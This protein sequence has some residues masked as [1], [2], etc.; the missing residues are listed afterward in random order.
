MGSANAHVKFARSD[1][2]GKQRIG[3][4]FWE[5]LAS[6]ARGDSTVVS[7]RLFSLLKK[8][9]DEPSTDRLQNFVDRTAAKQT[10]RVA[11][12]ENGGLLRIKDD[13]AQR[14]VDVRNR[15][16][17]LMQGHFADLRRVARESNNQYAIIL[18]Q[19]RAVET[20][21]GDWGFV[22]AVAEGKPLCSWTLDEKPIRPLHFK[23][24]RAEGFSESQA[25]E[26]LTKGIE[27][28]REQIASG[29]SSDP[30]LGPQALEDR[31]LA[32]VREQPASRREVRRS[33]SS[34]RRL[35]PDRVGDDFT[36][37]TKGRISK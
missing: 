8:S 24:F 13:I 16:M 26:C 20:I 22:A 21:T 1:V 32:Q 35:V 5:H 18:K 27:D 12:T 34:K 6:K 25:L 14:V 23:L 29:P 3:S 9:P 31:S 19:A 7:E 2:G 28:V 17:A 33:K 37:C 30:P 15:V 10:Y 4:P 11:R 36:N